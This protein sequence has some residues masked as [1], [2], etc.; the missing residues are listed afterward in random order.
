MIGVK[1]Y[2]VAPRWRADEATVFPIM[3]VLSKLRV[4]ILIHSDPLQ[5]LF[6]LAERFPEATIIM[7]H[8]GGGGSPTS[9]TGAIHDSRRY[10]NIY[11]DTTTSLVESNMVEEAVKVVGPERVLFG[12]DYPCLDPFVQLTKVRYAGVNDEQKSLILGENM[13]RLIGRRRA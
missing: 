5:P 4:P 8:M 2:P 11:L 3:E 10:E 7:A 13:M 6:N 12:T 9:I 1:L